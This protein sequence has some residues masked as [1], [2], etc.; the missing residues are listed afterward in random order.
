MSSKNSGTPSAGP[1]KQRTS[2]QKIINYLANQM[3][4]SRLVVAFQA[5][6]ISWLLP[7][8]ESGQ[9]NFIWPSHLAAFPATTSKG[10]QP[11]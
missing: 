2:R 3:Q 1:D 11:T 8:S 4:I 5:M 10:M 6:G 9:I 7:P